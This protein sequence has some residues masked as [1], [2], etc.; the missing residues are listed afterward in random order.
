MSTLT[1]APFAETP[2][3]AELGQELHMNLSDRERLVSTIS[4]T[5]LFASGLAR[6]GFARWLFLLVGAALLRRAYTVHCPAY[7]LAGLDRRHSH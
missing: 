6:T 1:Y 5:A 7:D 2:A 3:V 4:G